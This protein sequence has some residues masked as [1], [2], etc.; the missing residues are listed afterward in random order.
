MNSLGNEGNFLVLKQLDTSGLGKAG[1]GKIRPEEVLAV[2]KLVEEGD[3]LWLN[4]VSS[5][6]FARDCHKKGSEIPLSEMAAQIRT[7]QGTSPWT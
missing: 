1:Q 5:I 7:S 3:E 2:M 4:A 6:D